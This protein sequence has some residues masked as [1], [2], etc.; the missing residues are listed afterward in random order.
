[1]A[2]Q[3]LEARWHNTEEWIEV[4]WVSNF[5]E[6]TVAAKAFQ[7]DRNVTAAIL[8]TDH[9]GKRWGHS[10]WCTFRLTPV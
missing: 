9:E 8:W 10:K 2:M 4:D 6:A 1:M 5:G 3:T 7:L